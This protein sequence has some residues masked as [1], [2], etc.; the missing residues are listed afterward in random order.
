MTQ[1]DYFKGCK[2]LDEA[3]KTYYRLAMKFHPDK[4]GD[5]ERFKELANQFH[6]FKPSQVKYEKEFNDWSSK[7][8]SDIVMALMEIPDIIIEICGSWIWISGDTRTRK[9]LIKSAPTN[10]FYQRGFSAQKV[11]WHFSPI[12]YKKRSAE[13]L[14]MEAIR[15]IYGSDEFRSR[16]QKAIRKRV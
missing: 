15:N 13:E 2:T 7:A 6:S 3:R 10:D 16:P 1:T 9:G 5:E 12:G 8:Y 14:D 11:M 4:G